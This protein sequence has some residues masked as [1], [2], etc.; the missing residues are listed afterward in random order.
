MRQGGEWEGP[1]SVY[2][3]CLLPN[4]SRRKWFPY[5]FLTKLYPDWEDKKNQLFEEALREKCPYTEIVLVRIF[6][7]SD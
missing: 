3:A 5:N 6:P 7:H 2:D 4:N 1:D